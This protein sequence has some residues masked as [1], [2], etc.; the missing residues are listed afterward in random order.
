M[1]KVEDPPRALGVISI[2]AESHVMCMAS[3]TL[4]S[5]RSRSKAAWYSHKGTRRDTSCISQPRSAECGGPLRSARAGACRNRRSR[6]ELRCAR[7]AAFTITFLT[8]TNPA[9]GVGTFPQSKSAVGN[10]EIH[11][12]M[13]NAYEGGASTVR[14][15]LRVDRATGDGRC[16]APSRRACDIAG[17]PTVRSPSECTRSDTKRSLAV[18]GS[19]RKIRHAS[20]HVYCSIVGE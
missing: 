2:R 5:P 20:A 9:T 19:M 6:D 18:R 8:G 16:R 14:N 13:A 3:T 7:R 11:S 17:S 12:A 4:T 1:C 10:S 15:E